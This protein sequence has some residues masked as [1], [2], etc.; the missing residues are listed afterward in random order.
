M[1]K[2]EISKFILKIP[3]NKQFIQDLETTFQQIETLQNEVKTTEELYKKLIKEL[4]QE[5]I[6]QQNKITEKINELIEENLEE[7][8]EEVELIEIEKEVP[9]KKTI[10]KI[11]KI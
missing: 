8:L 7:N 9:K 5:A 10:K 11:K 6:P 1:G 3:Q 2:T 4:S